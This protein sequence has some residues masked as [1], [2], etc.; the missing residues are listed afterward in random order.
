MFVNFK[1]Q[2]NTVNFIESVQ[3]L[4]VDD[5]N[6]VWTSVPGDLVLTMKIIDQQGV[7]RISATNSDGSGYLTAFV[8]GFIEISIP[9]ISSLHNG[10]HIIEMIV[11]T[12]GFKFLLFQGS[13]PI[14]GD[15]R[16]R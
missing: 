11:E 2:R 15:S 3:V 6:P 1:P 8:N 10:R 16:C 14:I 12:G 4:S 5:D 9:D 7:E 13:L